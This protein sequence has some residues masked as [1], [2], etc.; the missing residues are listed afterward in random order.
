MVLLYW[1]FN[2]EMQDVL[3]RKKFIE[4]YDLNEAHI[5]AERLKFESD[6]DIEKAMEYCKQLRLEMNEQAEANIK[7]DIFL[8]MQR[9]KPNNDDIDMISNGLSAVVKTNSNVTSSDE[10]YTMSREQ[11]EMYRAAFHNVKIV[12]VDEVSMESGRGRLQ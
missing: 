11:L 5:L 4:M 1:P 7:Q 12:F 10:Y 6:F 8:Q 3:D 2:N 9:E